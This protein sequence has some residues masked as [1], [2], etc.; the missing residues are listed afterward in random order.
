MAGAAHQSV[1]SS[2]D[3]ANGGPM[4]NRSCGG[5]QPGLTL[6]ELLVVM[7]I[8][9][10]VM[11]FGVPS[12]EALIAN[13][14]RTAVVNGLVGHLQLA[15]SEAVKRARAVTICASSANGV[16]DGAAAEWGT[17]YV[18]VVGTAATGYGDV[19]RRTGGAG[20]ISI[21]GRD[22]TMIVYQADGTSGGSTATLLV[23]DTGGTAA[24]RAVVIN[25]V[26]RALVRDRRDSDVACPGG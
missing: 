5:S 26:G 14:A 23:C 24:P 21:D 18:V 22:R 25:N 6:V 10:I 1:R 19:L 16:C 7:A 11:V 8:V 3:T 2:M 4:K 9:G 15:R 20:R 13:N 17:G 12:F